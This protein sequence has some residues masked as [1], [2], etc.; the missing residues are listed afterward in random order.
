MAFIEKLQEYL[1][2]EG[3][4]PELTEFGLQ[5]KSENLDFLSF[6]DDQD[7]LFLNL[8]FPQIFEV[9]EENRADVYAALNK[10]NADVKVAKGAVRFENAV[11]AGVEMLLSD[12]FE[13]GD[14]VPRSL[15]MMIYYRDAFYQA[16]AATPTGKAEI[17]R[18]Q[19]QQQDAKNK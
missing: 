14:V 5:F 6:K 1:K 12:N 16:Y 8:F 11:W 3:Y 10:A 4:L 17:A 15:N 9:T 18:L 13:L 19:A 7:E 2:K